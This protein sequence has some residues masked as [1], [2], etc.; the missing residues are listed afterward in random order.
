M[1]QGEQGAIAPLPS[2]K[3][4][5]GQQYGFTPSPPDLGQNLQ[6]PGKFAERTFIYFILLIYF[7]SL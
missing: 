5:A 2:S 7:F 4:G 6:F 3:G 1:E